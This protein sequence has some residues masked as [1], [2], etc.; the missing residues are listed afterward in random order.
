MELS[1]EVLE[2]LHQF[3][4]EHLHTFNHSLNVSKYSTIIGKKLGLKGPEIER[5]KVAGLLHDIGKLKIPNEILHKAG[6]L[7]A[8]EFE[9]MK[10]HPEYSV[11]LLESVNF[12]DKEILEAIRLHHERLDGTGY[13]THTK[14]IPI[15]ARIISISDSYDAI[16]SHRA[17][18]ESKDSD[19]ARN[20]LLQNAGT[21]FDINLTLLFLNYLDEEFIRNRMLQREKIQE[22]R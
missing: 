12:Q 17:Y 6:R 9:I 5:L 4:K 7:T 21:Q 10:R 16:I 19:Y 18:K 15:F 8:E 13:P 20:E 22:E 1:N 14:D 2:L 11:K 3:K